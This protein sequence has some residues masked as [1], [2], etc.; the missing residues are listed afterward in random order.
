MRRL[1]HMFELEIDL[2]DLGNNSDELI[3]SMKDKI[4]ELE[5]KLPQLKIRDYLEEITGQFTE[6][7]FAPLSDVWKRELGDLFEDLD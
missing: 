1:N 6:R 2:T 3:N 7:S 5:E 4:D